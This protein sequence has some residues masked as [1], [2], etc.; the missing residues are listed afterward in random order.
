MNLT[1][2][3]IRPCFQFRLDKYNLLQFMRVRVN[4]KSPLLDEDDTTRNL[5]TQR[6]PRTRTNKHP[7]VMSETV[8]Q[9]HQVCNYGSKQPANWVSHRTHLTVS[10]PLLTLF[11]RV[12]V[13]LCS[14]RIQLFINRSPAQPSPRSRNL[15]G[16]PCPKSETLGSSFT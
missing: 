11:Q 1:T 7:R 2:F 9:V 10:I 8:V 15:H 12:D 6:P 13:T 16:Q 3:I 14:P 4:L 5:K